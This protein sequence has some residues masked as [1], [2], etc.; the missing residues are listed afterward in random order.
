MARRHARLKAK[1]TRGSRQVAGRSNDNA[2]MDIRAR[3]C[4]HGRSQELI[5]EQTIKGAVLVADPSI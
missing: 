2:H 5:K 1:D 3:R 4:R